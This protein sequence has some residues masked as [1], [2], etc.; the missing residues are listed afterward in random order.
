SQEAPAAPEDGGRTV[1]AATGPAGSLVYRSPEIYDVATGWKLEKEVAFFEEIFA[2]HAGEVHGILEPCCG[3]GRLLHVL[4]HRG[5]KVAGYDLSPPMV[6]Y[7]RERVHSFGGDVWEGDMATF[8]PPGTF[9]AGLNLVNSIGYLLED[10]EV[11]SHLRHMGEAIR[12]GGIYVV[13][14]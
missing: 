14:L 2:R 5:Y 4:A 13:Q 12:A 6:A 11:A 3:T 7:A 9:D 1:A 8:T 10:D